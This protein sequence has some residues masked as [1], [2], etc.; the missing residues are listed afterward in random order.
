MTLLHPRVLR[1][2]LLLLAVA[3][4]VLALLSVAWSR[5]DA[6][7]ARAGLRPGAGFMLPAGEFVGAYVTPAGTRVWCLS[8]DKALPSGV[9]LSTRTSWPGT[10]AT[11]AAAIAYA[12]ARWGAPRNRVAGA[13]QSQVLNTLAGNT[14][15]VAR[16]ARLLPAAY[17]QAIARQVAAHV[18][19]A[20]R[21]H[22]PYRA[23]VSLPSAVTPG[24]SGRGTVTVSAADGRPV[25]GVAVTLNHTANATAPARVRTDAH[26]RAR[27]TYSVT[28][29]G[30]VR[31]RA[32]AALPSRSVRVSSP[33][34]GEQR[35]VAVAPAVRAT[36]VTSFRARPGGFTHRYSCDTDCDGRPATVLRACAPA[37]RTASR[38]VYRVGP[39][40][41]V[42]SFPAGAR[43]TCVETRLVSRDGDR[44]SA[45]WQWRVH[46]RWSAPVAAAGTFVVDCPAPPPVAVTMTAGCV[47][48]RVTLGLAQPGAGGTWTPFRNT[49]R[50]AMVLLVSGDRTARVVAARGGEAMWTA[51][52]PCGAGLALTARPAVQRASGG[53]NYG[54]SI[55]IRTP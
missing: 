33:R 10:S 25:A 45:A 37:A 49:S 15:D 39:R 17:R 22:G 55:A 7:A 50:H 42:A 19:A 54:P 14:R 18:A 44:V 53:W 29:T 46:G 8:P 28:G 6:R 40:S 32:T 34:P 26:G 21:L 36:A 3:G 1:R 48:A 52:V 23:R 41:V 51:T 11:R 31:V 2:A 47:N 20:R 12:L 38:L 4:C 27:F 9:V 24:R 35:M 43:R 30:E 16:R 13:V 5:D